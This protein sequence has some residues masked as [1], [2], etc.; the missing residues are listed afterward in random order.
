MQ[1]RWRSLSQRGNFRE[2]LEPADL[3]SSEITHNEQPPTYDSVKETRGRF[4]VEFVQDDKIVMEENK[5]SCRN[6]RKNLRAYGANNNNNKSSM[7]LLTKLTQKPV[8]PPIELQDLQT[9]A[10]VAV[11]VEDIPSTSS[12]HTE[13]NDSNTKD[14]SREAETLDTMIESIL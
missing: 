5:E 13:Q 10:P 4:H 3:Q 11:N 2:A 1:L 6:G 9:S 12:S 14:F 8:A 7:P